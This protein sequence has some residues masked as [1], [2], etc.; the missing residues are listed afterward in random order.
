MGNQDSTIINNAEQCN[1][2]QKNTVGRLSKPFR[3]EQEHSQDTVN[4]ARDAWRY[5]MN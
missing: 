1:R 5:R 2:E 4:H 3:V